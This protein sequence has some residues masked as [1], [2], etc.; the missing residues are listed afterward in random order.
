M[1]LNQ[2]KYILERNFEGIF[3]K[4]SENNRA[5]FVNS[6]VLEVVVNCIDLGTWLRLK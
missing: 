3:E 4:S 1:M 5:N 6:H 2:R